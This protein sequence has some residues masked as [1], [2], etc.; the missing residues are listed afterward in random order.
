MHKTLSRVEVKDADR[1]TVSAVF[2]TFN[3]VDSD[4]DVTP[5]GAFEDG[6]PWAISAYG[7]QSWMGALPVGKGIARVTDTE[8]ILDG[9]FFLNT[10]GGRDTFEVVKQMG[11]RQ[12]WS[13]SVHVLKESFGDFD[14]K[15]VRFL[16]KLGNGEVSPV[17]KG[18]GVGTRTL[19]V[20]NAPTL[21]DE[22][23]EAMGVVTGVIDSAER[24]AAL[25]A[26]KGKNLSR[27]NREWLDGLERELRRL[28]A[29]VTEAEDDS[30][31]QEE[32]NREYLR[33]LR[34]IR[35]A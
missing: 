28:K 22:L 35:A 2:S 34:R 12:E 11:D 33:F 3:V 9:Q 1:G 20:K 26:E 25:R 27:T 19:A 31:Y 21:E 29:L 18:A 16:E 6:A 24:V 13:Y 7:H 17:L 15:R 8:A 10:T 30:A 23:T 14:G 5:P 4:N 32:A